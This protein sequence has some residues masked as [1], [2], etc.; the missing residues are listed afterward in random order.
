[1]NRRC[2]RLIFSKILG[3]LIPVAEITTS[4]GKKSQGA[5]LHAEAAQPP[6][7]PLLPVVAV[8]RTLQQSVVEVRIVAKTGGRALM[9]AMVFAPGIASA[10]P[11]ADPAAGINK[12]N[13]VAAANG[14]PVI[15]IVDPNAAGLSHNKFQSFDVAAP[16]TVF[17]NSKVNGVTS[18]GG[19]TMNNPKLSQEAKGILVD[20][21]GANPSSL[22]GT[23]EVFGKKADLLISNQNGIT[24][25][26]VTTLNA[27]SLTATTGKPIVSPTG[28]QFSVSN[29]Q[30]TVG[31]AGV[32]T[33]G[34]SYF[35]IVARSIALQGAVGSTAQATDINAIAGL[36][37]YNVAT[38]KADTNSSSAAGTPAVAIDGTL[39]GAMYGRNIS[40]IST[41]TG[42]G[43]RHAGLIRA[44]Q[45]IS[46]SAQ[47]DITVATL[48]ADNQVSLNSTGSIHVGG[49][50]AG[51]GITAGKAV[52]LNAAQTMI[53]SNPVQGETLSLT[54]SSLLVQAA[55]LIATSTAATGPVK[56]VNIKVGDFTLSGT[57]VAYNLDGVPV[58]ANQPLVISG[59]KLQVR[60]SADNS[61]ENFTLET[62][63]MVISHNGVNIEADTVV[64]DGGIVQD[65][66]TGGIN[67][68]TRQLTNKGVINT[69]GDMKLVSEVFK[70]LCAGMTQQICAGIL[71]GGKAD[72]Q[73]GKLTNQ[74]GLVS[75]SDLDLTLKDQSTSSDF[76]SITAQGQMNIKQAAGNK[77]TLVS[78]GQIVSGGDLLVILEALSN[79]SKDAKIHADGKATFQISASLANAGM[80]EAVQ[81][82]DIAAGDFLNSADSTVKTDQSLQIVTNKKLELGRNS[83]VH[84]GVASKLSAGTVLQ[85]AAIVTAGTTLDMHADDQLINDAG[86]SLASNVLNIS[87]DQL[88]N[89]QGSLISVDDQLNIKVKG[90]VSNAGQSF[91]LSGG[92]ISIVAGGNVSNLVGSVVS[93]TRNVVIDANKVTNS[94][95]ALG[96]NATANDVSTITGAGVTLKAHSDVRNDTH[97]NIVA[98]G[99]LDIQTDGSIS[100][101]DA[102]M[103]GSDVKLKAG[104]GIVN[105]NASIAATTNDIAVQAGGSLTN[106]NASI[107]GNAVSIDADGDVLNEDLAVIS[108]KGAMSLNAKG[109]GS[110]VNKNSQLLGDQIV[111]TAGKDVN[112]EANSL[113]NAQENLDIKAAGSMTNLSSEMN[114]LAV[115]LNAGTDL[116]NESSAVQANSTLDITAGGALTNLSSE[117]K[118]SKIA[119]DAGGSLR[120]EASALIN[121]VGDLSL[122]A[123]DFISNLTSTLEGK[124]VQ[125]IAKGTLN[126]AG[127]SKITASEALAVAA[128]GSV[129]NDHSALTGTA[130]H[131]ISGADITNNTAVMTAT[132]GDLDIRASGFVA[133]LGGAIS[134]N[135]VSINAGGKVRNDTG[136]IISAKDALA[137]QAADSIVNS[138]ASDVKGSSIII[139]A[140]TDVINQASGLI[141]TDGT[142]DIKA[143][144]G[145]TN[146][147]SALQG[148]DVKIDA[149]TAIRNEDSSLIYAGGAL[150][151]KA[152]DMFTNLSS[153]V[154]GNGI[155][156]D[157]GNNVRNETG[158]FITALSDLGIK[159]GGMVSNLASQLTGK[160]VTIDAGSDVRN[161]AESVIAA[162]SSLDIQSL[163]SVT[164]VASTIKGAET[165]IN[166][167]GTVTNAEKASIIS[168]SDL[169]ISSV[170][171]LQNDKGSAIVAKG[172]VDLTVGSLANRAGS[173]ILGNTVGI[174]AHGDISNETAA[175]VKAT[176]ALDIKADGALINTQAGLQGRTVVA[177][178]KGDASNTSDALIQGTEG[179]TLTTANNLSN[180]H[181]QIQGKGIAITANQVNNSHQAVIAGD[182]IGVTAAG[183]VSN[184]NG[185]NIK[186]TTS[187]AIDSQGALTNDASTIIG[188]TVALD[189]LQVTNT[190][191]SIAGDSIHINSLSSLLN[192][193]K[194]TIIA[195]AE[196]VIEAAKGVLNDDSLIK[197]PTVKVSGGKIDNAAGANI[198]GDTVSLTSDQDIT[199]RDA[200]IIKGD[201]Q[202]TM[203]AQGD[204]SNTGNA[205]ITTPKLT[206]D[207][208]NVSNIQG[209]KILADDIAIQAKNDFVSASSASMKG[210]QIAIDTTHFHGANSEIL[211]I[212]DIDI[213]TADYANTAN[214]SSENTAT[215]TI[216]NDGNLNIA[217][218]HL[219]PLAKQLLTLNAHDVTTNAELNNPGSIHVNAAGDVHNNQGIITGKSLV[220]K[221]TGAIENA[222][223]QIVFAAQD[224]TLEAGSSISN[225]KD[226]RI[227]AMGNVSLTATEV[228]NDLGRITSGESMSIDADTII[229]QGAA[230][231]GPVKIKDSRSLLNGLA[232][233]GYEW[234]HDART[235]SVGVVMQL[236]VYKSDMTVTQA[237]IESGGDLNINQ[238]SRRGKHAQVTN[239]DSLMTASGNIN[240]DGNISNTST[241]ASKSISQLLDD[242]ITIV[243]GAQDSLDMG[244]HATKAYS[245]LW[246]LLSD[247]Y[248]PDNQYYTI[249]GL[250]KYDDNQVA[251]ALK[252]IE[253]PVFN[254]IMSAAFGA[255][256]KGLSRDQMAGR[257]NQFNRGALISYSS[258]KK[259]EIAAGGTFT[260]TGGAFNNGGE[261]KEQQTV[262]VQVG[263]KTISTIQGNFDRQFNNSV[264]FDDSKTPSFV[265]LTAAMNPQNV[266]DR[267][268][269]TTPLFTIRTSPP[270]LVLEGSDTPLIPRVRERDPVIGTTVGFS[271][272]NLDR[273]LSVGQVVKVGKVGI[274][275]F[276]SAVARVNTEIVTVPVAAPVPVVYTPIFPLYETRIAYIDQSKFYGSQ[277]FFDNIGYH[278]DRTVPVIGD[279]FFDNQLITQTIQDT[280]GGYFA[281]KDGVSG[282]ELVKM[283]MD[284]AADEEGPLGLKFGVPLTAA[285]YANLTSDIIW[286][287]PV[288][289]NGASVLS[290]KVYLSKATLADAS[291]NR[292]AT[293]LVA[294][295]GAV[296]IDATNVSNVDGAIRGDSVSIKSAGK[297]DNQNTGGG[298]VGIFAGST[299]SVTLDA[300]GDIRNIGSTVSGKN[301]AI[302]TDG[303]FTDSVRMGYDD[304]GSLVL[305]DRG[306]IDGG[307]DGSVSIDAAGDVS[308]TAAGMA[309]K[310]VSVQAGGNLDSNDIHEVSSSFKQTVE[311]NGFNLGALKIALGKTTKTDEE[312]SASSVGSQLQGGADEGSL[313]LR[314][315]KNITLKGG[316]YNAD[317]GLIAAKGGVKTITGQNLNYSEK[318]MLSEGLNLGVSAGIA[319]KGVIAEYGP[320]GASARVVNGDE[321]NNPHAS[322]VDGGLPA[323]D[324]PLGAKIGYQRIETKDTRMQV[325]NQNAQLNFGSSATLQGGDTVDIGGADIQAVKDGKAGDLSIVGSDVIS[326]KY[327]DED[328]QTHSRKELV[329]GVAAT[330]SS[331]IAD[332]VNHST[333]LA[334]KAKQ[335]MTVDAGMTALQ[336]VGDA[337][338]LVF[339]DTGAISGKAG[340]KYT[341]STSSSRNVSENINTLKGNIKITSTQGD[342]KLAGVALD[343]TGAGVELDSA[344]NVSLSAAKSTSESQS[345]TQTHDV[346]GS[347]S[348][349]AAPTG[350]G[351]G[352]SASYSG[353]L[354][355]TQT[356]GVA[357]Q[358][359]QVLGDK[360]VIKA[361][362]DLE[363]TGA[364][365]TGNDVDLDIAGNTRVTSVQDTSDMTHKVGNWGGNVGAAVTTTSIVAPTGG[366]NGGGGKDTDHSA[367]TAEQSG[368][369]AKNML[370]ANIGGDLNLKGA[371]LISQSGQGALKVAGAIK[372][373]QLQDSRQKDGGGGGGGGGL[374]KT[375]LVSV[376]VNVNRVDQVH[377]DATQNATIAGLQVNSAQG[378]EGTLNRDANKTLNVT[379]DEHIAGNDVTITAGIPAL[380]GVV[381]KAKAKAVQPFKASP[382]PKALVE[383]QRTTKVTP[384]DAA[385]DKPPV[386]AA[387][388]HA[389]KSANTNGPLETTPVDKYDS[390]VIVKLESDPATDQAA[391]RIH[392]K[393]P[394]NSVLLK[395]D[396]QGQHTVVAGDPQSIGGKTKVEL[397]GHG[398]KAPDGSPTLGGLK[399][400]EVAQE[401]VKVRD[402]ARGNDGAPIDVKKVTAV[403]CNTGV[404]ADGPSLS[405]QVGKS[406]KAQGID[407]PTRG[408][409]SRIDL[410]A[411]GH[412]KPV[413]DG[414]LM[415]SI[416]DGVG[417]N[418]RASEFDAPL[419][420]DEVVIQLPGNS[421][422][423]IASGGTLTSSAE[424]MDVDHLDSSREKKNLV[425]THNLTD[426]QTP[427]PFSP[428]DIFTSERKQ[429]I[430]GDKLLLEFKKFEGL[431][432]GTARHKA[433][434][435]Y[436]ALAATSEIN[437]SVN[438]G[439]IDSIRRMQNILEFDGLE[440]FVD[441]SKFTIDQ[442]N[443]YAES[444]RQ[445]LRVREPENTSIGYDLTLQKPQLGNEQR[446]IGYEIEMGAYFSDPALPPH[447][448]LA[449]TSTTSQFG[450][451]LLS[452][453]IDRMPNR[454]PQIEVVTGPMKR[455]TRSSKEYGQAMDS[456]KN[457]IASSNSLEDA[458]V[459]HNKIV[460]DDFKLAISEHSK[461]Y[462][463]LG[464]DLSYSLAFP[465]NVKLVA[466]NVQTTV[467]F[468]YLALAD[469]R[470]GLDHL[471]ASDIPLTRM[472]TASRNAADELM[473]DAG[474]SIEQQSPNLKAVLVQT[475]FEM[476]SN[477]SVGR[478]PDFDFKSKAP[479]IFRTPPEH[480]APYIMT[481]NERGMAKQ[482]L[483]SETMSR[484]VIDA[485][486]SGL[487]AEKSPQWPTAGMEK[488][489]SSSVS[490]KVDLIK[491]RLEIADKVGP[492]LK[493]E[494]GFIPTEN[495]D[496]SYIFARPTMDQTKTLLPTL[497][498]GNI[499]CAVEL[500]DRTSFKGFHRSHKGTG[501]L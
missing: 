32:D 484:H 422:E 371:Q 425:A 104:T 50:F 273:H 9:T 346:S 297:I 420:A 223:A 327:E 31:T 494:A 86:T 208:V 296:S 205:T 275:D 413:A 482:V 289:I 190:N 261:K 475:I 352:I 220:V 291:K 56:S 459:R 332:T 293:T 130:V 185:S 269:K 121:A 114:G 117:L 345:S 387:D 123:G 469:G 302:H 258:D 171:A 447:F 286:Y 322:P 358:N 116:H 298:T 464:G 204:V 283:L 140:G 162:A 129:A 264:L 480:I 217:D 254:Q 409:D 481:P 38:R 36:N 110:V 29:G 313:T 500:R 181:S 2:F 491:N 141:K 394:E 192:T 282:A 124:T 479:L 166:A 461:Q 45:D 324:G 315:G 492:F 278:S 132:A 6:L 316:D 253:N 448:P 453:Q 211:A 471:F 126:N 102:T 355:E 385:V 202:V 247:V 435:I 172:D 231:G 299:G 326:T 16:G 440:K 367:L 233:G 303:S 221:A 412:K 353:S 457:A 240:V 90:D 328:V 173:E 380:K 348:A 427:P 314:A 335:G 236:P 373:E 25:N 11:I 209:G 179:V 486:R 477:L 98:T 391:Q 108:A 168:D 437:L 10:L 227:M 499:F 356:T 441:H 177:K 498:A 483:N 305:K 428:L 187:V 292:G 429:A 225:L 330:G 71:A 290:P 112:N 444:A 388:S 301:V 423:S 277:Y 207:G 251:L 107:S 456:L 216:K 256:W 15:E 489:I 19:F 20:V 446:L 164:N 339:N 212:D 458:V 122:K 174:L 210:N 478:N 234:S 250:Y 351:V 183:A 49:G 131:I 497:C 376:N 360:V 237:V 421:S 191:A 377:Y 167:K 308:L 341:E 248:K 68:L 53:I 88:T 426:S 465:G 320:Q 490:H 501:A 26:G 241:E 118:G 3:F 439:T 318:T 176:G 363:L 361:K 266:L 150:S 294:S 105:Q 334:D 23:L 134:G 226:A 311:T 432:G 235:T 280:V 451:P 406:L 230:S 103:K 452:V 410:T 239:A 178:V 338:N 260:Q 362:K 321:A 34:L 462:L 255:D 463:S 94:G 350:A 443:L 58:A 87:G 73:A 368:I 39:A 74:A 408:Y 161:E 228:K 163:G 81:N 100:N 436:E 403:G 62:S 397:V 93:A 55:K 60:R 271:V 455:E 214:I 160:A 369:T 83:N 89:K 336:A 43:V 127:K 79:A 307:K 77:A 222:V 445:L 325:R 46:I 151:V 329:V 78:A 272:P 416:D 407:A 401:V 184:D 158:S 438:T 157:A 147:A 419:S 474:A 125:L 270:P 194:S 284:N 149:G 136:A 155:A 244:N 281:A 488:N 153:Q 8:L 242:P 276:G 4:R 22:A 175:L 63:A 366:A 156:I 193:A 295:K 243:V 393:H 5:G 337:T 201:T 59:G 61:D 379:R 188:S 378:I 442:S 382:A 414:G 35:D 72:L 485:V 323:L 96:A 198:L 70:N 75:G 259:A 219:A 37:T 48:Q 51:Q 41:E 115:Q 52:A 65:L 472:L 309:A 145:V 372:A 359:A 370:N 434:A 246:A 333:T 342:I 24:L 142:L 386:A 91:M 213:H 47:G 152:G 340:I 263:T 245:S 495:L 189:A 232:V 182:L 106:Q 274:A 57:L 417:G 146:L 375:G 357:Y 33:T 392:D 304:H 404:C 252:T 197:G 7:W 97:A 203:L 476:A 267:L 418:S 487:S 18:I 411:N 67:L 287:E 84:A 199:N 170:D 137:L 101:V 143:Q 21:T 450:W 249:W 109:S 76:G 66:G 40:L 384:G 383:P 306:R 54:A 390:R 148:N 389:Q 470:P 85:N 120:N 354:D 13:V 14:V 396:A 496:K 364:K 28:L 300:K 288:V 64:N 69:Q 493:T 460:S 473:T 398:D 128:Q 402:G 133:N 218:G 365:V 113:I 196:V 139:D 343:G 44:A 229:N 265:E 95:N 17:N 186:A 347:I 310:H 262:Q 424:L 80:M 154:Q 468:P 224:I 349:S 279:A 449:E 238:S 381:D 467:Q 317:K 331:S 374:S 159:A 400:N 30:V 399:A 454:A 27:N 180:D 138:N 268:T 415:M 319:G 1:M 111:I 344:R 312:V 433:H 215:L 92:D 285:Q 430:D 99:N 82:I 144:G 466:S 195:T 405:D 42:A 135:T 431:S 169:S 200:A 206:M 257:I 119:I 395:R 165:K 12:P